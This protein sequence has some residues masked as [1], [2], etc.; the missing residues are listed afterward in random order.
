MTSDFFQNHYPDGWNHCY[1]CGQLNE[2]GLKVESRWDG[3]ET[4]C[5]F[6]PRPEHKA[7]PGFVYGGLIASV[8]DCHSTGSAAGAR[9]RADGREIGEGP[10]PRFLTGR[11]TVEYL[12]PT[13]IDAPME[14][15]SKILEIKGRKVVV[16]TELHS[17]GVLC[18]RGEAVLIQ[19]PDSFNPGA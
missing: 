5:T 8:I 6:V 12:K 1:G 15:R 10:V 9:H 18:A 19:I 11:L 4:V 13:P 3:D 2:K 16:A 14:L 7:I 17:K